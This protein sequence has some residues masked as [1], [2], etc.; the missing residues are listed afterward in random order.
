TIGFQGLIITDALDMGAIR[1]DFGQEEAIEA[2]LL[3]GADIPLMPVNIHSAEDMSRVSILID[4]LVQR[5]NNNPQLAQR[6]HDAALRVITLK[7][8]RAMT[9]PPAV[10]LATAQ[11]IVGSAEH[12]A[13]EREIAEKAVTLIVNEGVLPWP[14]QQGQHLLLLSDT[15]KRNQI[16]ADELQQISRQLSLQLSTES[17]NFELNGD[18]LPDNLPNQ[19]IK[20]DLVVMLTYN[21]QRSN[22]AAQQVID[23]AHR[24]QRHV[25]VISGDTP[26]DIARLQG[27]KANIAI[28]GVTG[29]DQDLLLRRNPLEANLRAG[30]R[31]LFTHPS[32]QKLFFSPQ[33]RLPVAIYNQTGSLLYPF[34][35]HVSYQ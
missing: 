25:V 10:S 33:G 35:Y 9:A 2:A 34:G 32:A 23:L 16:M 11:R 20:N 17:V 6:I 22:S 27:V 28:Y 8:S 24:L 18:S 29:F 12:H 21:L 15:G 7:L 14:L 5:A 13:L 4:L 30:I 31:S 3:A 19:I 1:N 26:Y